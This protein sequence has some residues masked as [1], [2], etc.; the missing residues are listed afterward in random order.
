MD[1]VN[2]ATTL[3]MTN[4]AASTFVQVASVA[5]VLICL[6][7]DYFAVDFV[8]IIQVL[9]SLSGVSQRLL[10]ALADN[11]THAAI[12]LVAWSIA[13]YP[14]LNLY[15]LVAMAIL[16]S[17]VDLDHFVAAKSMQLHEALSLPTRPFMHNSLTLVCINVSLG[18]LASV[19]AT[20]TSQRRTLYTYTLMFFIA[21]FTH[22]LRDANRH[23]LWFGDLYTTG[24]LSRPVYIALTVLTAWLARY[25]CYLVNNADREL[26]MAAV[27]YSQ[28]KSQIV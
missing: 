20:S 11:G 15:Q 17:A 4:I 25:L 6:C 3:M 1:E 27:Q 13:T 21:W 10:H 22:H 23:G 8:G 26:P 14:R 9:S 16:T 5:L 18:L 2:D 19:F 28:L 24:K 12:G 7:G